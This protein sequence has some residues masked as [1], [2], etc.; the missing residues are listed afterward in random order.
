LPDWTSQG[1]Q[2]RARK[3]AVFADDPGYAGLPG[4]SAG[5]Y[6]FAPNPLTFKD[7]GTYAFDFGPLVRIDSSIPR[8]PVLL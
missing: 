3:E 8:C 2:R 6:A 4:S 7:P 1:D 5:D